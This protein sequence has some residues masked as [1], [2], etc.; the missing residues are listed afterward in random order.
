MRL[1]EG[2]KYDRPPRC[3]ECDE[4]LANCH[5]PPP[6]EPE[7][8]PELQVLRIG[9]EKRKKGKIVT[10][11]RGLAGENSHRE[12]L[13]ELKSSCGA[14]GRIPSE[15]SIEIQGEHADRIRQLL[16]RRGFQIRP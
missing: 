8:P 7:I 13:T 12:L 1:F 6:A 9:V 3:D 2:T 14:G 5:C 11:I 10:V 15:S 16:R 4:L